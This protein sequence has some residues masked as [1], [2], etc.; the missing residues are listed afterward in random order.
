MFKVRFLTGGVLEK[1][2]YVATSGGMAQERAMEIISSNLANMNT[3]GFKADR[4]MFQSY[5]QKSAQPPLNP[6]TPNEIKQ[7]YATIGNNDTVYKI[8]SQNYTDFTQGSLLSTG[9]HLDVALD[10][11]GFMAV[12][13]PEGERYT[14][15]GSLKLDQTGTLMTSEGYP[16][17][18]AN[19]QHINV[20]T[21][22]KPITIMEDGSVNLQ[23][24]GPVGQLKIVD[25]PD[26]TQIEKTGQGLY[27]AVDGAQMQ[28]SDALAKQGYLEG[29]NINPVGE[30]TRMITGLR[31]YES[32]QKVIQSHD[33]INQR[34]ISD[35]AR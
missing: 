32:F 18:D 26:K 16:V 3:H 20:D 28:P 35:V 23:D 33:E 12:Q 5:L 17:L 31:A 15:G 13:T 34:L 21:I 11:S 4:L 14:R 24:V 22:N 29:S 8:G 10:G 9:N 30:M 25:F 7:G 27:K 2:I 6:P 1:G 19:G